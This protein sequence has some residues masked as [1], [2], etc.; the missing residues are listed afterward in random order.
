MSHW[1]EVF[2]NE[3]VQWHARRQ[4]AHLSALAATSVL[5]TVLIV[6]LGLEGFIAMETTGG[7]LLVLWS[8][9]VWW[10]ASRQRK[11]RRVVWCIKL[12]EERVVGYDYT[13]R[14][15]VMAWPSVRRI[16]LTNKGLLMVGVDL[17]TFEVP[18]LFPD[19]AELSHR[20]VHYAEQH[21]VPVFI[22]GQPWQELDIYLLF[23]FL[24]D[25]PSADTGT[26]A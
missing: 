18:H 19:F 12:S 16:E 10:I 6:A 23:P 7:S 1:Y 14:K 9:T 2:D 4:A 8:G 17:C 21:G 11:L 26:A 22:D 15:A 20:I 3:E 5:T 24:A 25:D 13:R